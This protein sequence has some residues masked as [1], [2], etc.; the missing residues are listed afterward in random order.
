M[1]VHVM[2]DACCSQDDQLGPLENTYSLP[3]GAT[4][5]DLVRAV[6]DS[7]FLQFSSTHRCITASF[8]ACPL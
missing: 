5:M 3:S 6:V 8:Q 1:Q 4:V 2:R 7:Q